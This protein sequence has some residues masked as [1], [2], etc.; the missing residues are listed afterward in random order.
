MR[1]AQQFPR[2]SRGARRLSG[3]SVDLELSQLDGV[4]AYYKCL[5][6]EKVPDPDQTDQP[7]LVKRGEGYLKKVGKNS[8][9]TAV[10]KIPTPFDSTKVDDLLVIM[11]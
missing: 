9:S 5:L 4:N 7:R 11:K 2:I 6:F 3:S 8:G 10:F 1:L